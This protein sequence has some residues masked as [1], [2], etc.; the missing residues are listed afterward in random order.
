MTNQTFTRTN[1]FNRIEVHTLTAL[2]GGFTYTINNSVQFT[3]LMAQAYFSARK[4]RHET[5]P[6]LG[7]NPPP[8]PPR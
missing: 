4:R 1:H 7:L 2:R 8:H 6:R 5:P 3:G